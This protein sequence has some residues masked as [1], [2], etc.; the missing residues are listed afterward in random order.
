MEKSGNI[1][2]L[3]TQVEISRYQDKDYNIIKKWFLAFG[4]TPPKKDYLPLNG[5][6]IYIK[7][8]PMACGFVY[9]T[10]SSMCLFDFPVSNPAGTKEERDMAINEL[11]NIVKEYSK[12]AGYKVI[13]TSKCS[14]KFIDRLEK[15]GFSS[16]SSG[17][18]H[19]F[20]GVK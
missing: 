14:K 11:I 8:K 4:H 3:D 7:K 15:Q 16:G 12:I 13:Y 20:Y 2:F 18:V 6:M 17:N 19:L 5:F 9:N 1:E 10:D